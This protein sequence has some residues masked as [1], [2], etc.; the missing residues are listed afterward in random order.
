VAALAALA[1]LLFVLALLIVV[2]SGAAGR[3][4]HNVYVKHFY[5][6][7]NFEQMKVVFRADI[8]RVMCLCG[9]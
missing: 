4:H 6:F 5:N 8:F 7:K 1:F 3:Y 9:M 2:N